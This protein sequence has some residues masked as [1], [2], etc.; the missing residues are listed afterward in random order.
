MKR[1]TILAFAAALLTAAGPARAATVTPSAVYLTPAS[2]VATL[3]IT[4]DGME[5]EEIEIRFGWGHP[6]ADSLG[7]PSIWYLEQAPA[8]Q[9]NAM[10][11]LR[12]FPRRVLLEPGQTQ[13]VRVIATPPA[14]L[15]DGEYWARVVIRSTPPAAPV[16]T[17]TLTE[18]VQ[19]D[20]VH[21]T[22]LGVT[23]RQ[24]AMATDISATLVRAAATG[25]SA[26][27]LIDLVRSGNAAWLGRVRGQLVAPDG[28]VL[29]TVEIPVAVFRE[30]RV[31]LDLASPGGIPAGATVRYTFDNDRP[32]LPPM[33]PIPSRVVE[34]TVTLPQR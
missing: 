1:A 33:G 10:P 23:Y 9:P 17:G 13:L 15:A 34:G 5:P 24:G 28:R 32:D 21:Q 29:D 12:A 18:G 16:S 7:N 2:P 11:F 22:I 31:R 19:L 30:L 20:V 3:A 14:G 6:V 8:G 26:S 4:N 27:V 25:D